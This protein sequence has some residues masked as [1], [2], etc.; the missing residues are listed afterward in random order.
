M[1]SGIPVEP[2]RHIPSSRCV[3]SRFDGRSSSFGR[4]AD[5]D[6][7]PTALRSRS[8]PARRS[9]RD[10]GSS[11]GLSPMHQVAA[12]RCTTIAHARGGRSRR[13]NPP[14]RSGHHVAIEVSELNAFTTVREKKS[15]SS[16]NRISLA[17]TKNSF[18][19]THSLDPAVAGCPGCQRWSTGWGGHGSP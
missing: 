18:V 6:R 4:R 8:S 9:N 10:N 13:V 12:V 14:A 2:V 16:S 15:R 7:S 19:T 17:C 11:C 5:D 3:T 1:A